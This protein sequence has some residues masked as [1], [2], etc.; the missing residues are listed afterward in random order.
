MQVLEKE[1]SK[2]YYY[3]YHCYSKNDGKQA[4]GTTCT[5]EKHALLIHL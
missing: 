5:K 1:Y 4:F 3:S 2:D